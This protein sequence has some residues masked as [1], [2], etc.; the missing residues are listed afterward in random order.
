MGYISAMSDN[1]EHKTENTSLPKLAFSMRETAQVMGMSYIS[2]HR[3]IKRGKLKALRD[4]RHKIIPRTEI[5]R[6]LKEVA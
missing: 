1:T 3:L 6:F 5:E 4:F 2:V